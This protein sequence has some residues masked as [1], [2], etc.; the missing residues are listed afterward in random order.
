MTCPRLPSP[1][2]SFGYLKRAVPEPL[3]APLLVCDRRDGVRLAEEIV[4]REQV[5][6]R[7]A[8]ILAADVVGYSRLMGADEEGTLARL[9][10][11]PPGRVDPTG[12][13]PHGR[14]VT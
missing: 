6:R 13:G 7:M 11:H 10:A 4:E 3:A 2:V 5:N 12:A 1:A 9:K 14:L 8:A